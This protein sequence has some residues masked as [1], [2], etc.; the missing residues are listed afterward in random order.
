[1]YF[2]TIML[3]IEMV[4]TMHVFFRKV[5]RENMIL[6]FQIKI[7]SFNENKIAYYLIKY[8]NRQSDCFFFYKKVFK[9]GFLKKIKPYL[10]IKLLIVFQRIVSLD[11]NK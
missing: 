10:K 6:D 3:N 4:Y 5:Y 8:I 2:T 9:F 11:L 7:S 1:M